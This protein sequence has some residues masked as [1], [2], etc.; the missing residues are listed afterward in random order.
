MYWT[1][2]SIDNHFK[3]W[4]KILKRAIEGAREHPQ[5]GRHWRGMALD[6]KKLQWASVEFIVICLKAVHAV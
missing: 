1:K 5:A 3:V 6:G 2:S 4:T